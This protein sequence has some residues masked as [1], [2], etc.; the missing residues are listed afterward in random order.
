MTGF[1]EPRDIAF[2]TTTFNIFM[3]LMVLLGGKGTL[4]GPVVGAVVFH[5]IKE[6]TWTYFLGWQ[7]IAL[8]LL[9]VIIVVYFQQGIVGWLME[10]YP[11]WSGLEVAAG[12]VPSEPHNVGALPHPKAAE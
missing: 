6:V 5:L 4:W 8:G 2:P 1:I 10:R 11:Q 3:V 12:K 7:F 9:I